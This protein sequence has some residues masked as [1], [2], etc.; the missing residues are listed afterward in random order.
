MLAGRWSRELNPTPSEH[1]GLRPT[2]RR[3]LVRTSAVDVT[4]KASI[5]TSHVTSLAL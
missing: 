3:C 5:H 1:D 2:Q 4:Y